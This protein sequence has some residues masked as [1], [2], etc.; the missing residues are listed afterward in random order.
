M[1]G[2]LCALPAQETLEECLQPCRHPGP[3]GA[4]EADGDAGGDHR[5]RCMALLGW[6]FVYYRTCLASRRR[7]RGTAVGREEPRTPFEK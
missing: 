2:N 5:G 6:G 4:D 7:L 3:Q 1:V